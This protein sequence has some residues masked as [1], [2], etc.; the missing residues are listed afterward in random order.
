MGTKNQP[1]ILFVQ[2]IGCGTNPNQSTTQ[3]GI[4]HYLLS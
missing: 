4:K 2:K 3:F 1:N